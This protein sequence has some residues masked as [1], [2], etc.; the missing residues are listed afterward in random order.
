M[1]NFRGQLGRRRISA[2]LHVSGVATPRQAAADVVKAFGDIGADSERATTEVSLKRIGRVLPEASAGRGGED[3][4]T[5]NDAVVYLFEAIATRNG[6]LT[7]RLSLS[8][9]ADCAELSESAAHAARR[10]GYES[11]CKYRA[12][13]RGQY[14]WRPPGC[15]GS[16]RHCRSMQSGTSARSTIRCALCFQRV[17]AI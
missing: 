12:V 2:E 15:C 11:E 1:R 6:T 8:L 4:W 17:L 10:D 14:L 3:A 9:C 16:T 13:V 7:V 5:S